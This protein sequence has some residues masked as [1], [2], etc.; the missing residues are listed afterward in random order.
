MTYIPEGISAHNL[1]Q[2]HRQNLG[3]LVSELSAHKSLTT[4]FLLEMVMS[5]SKGVCLTVHLI[6]RISD[7]GLLESLRHTPVSDL[8]N[9]LANCV[10]A[11]L[12]C[13]REA[14]QAG[15]DHTAESK[16]H[17]LTLIW[18][19]H[20][21]LALC[22]N[23]SL[24]FGEIN[25][26]LDGLAR[27]MCLAIFLKFVNTN[28]SVN[29]APHLAR[30]LFESYTTSYGVHSDPHRGINPLSVCVGMIVELASLSKPWNCVFFEEICFV[31]SRCKSQWL[32]AWEMRDRHSLFDEYSISFDRFMKMEQ[33]QPEA[34]VE[35]CFEYAFYPNQPISL[36][37]SKP[38][39][40]RH[41]GAV[42][43]LDSGSS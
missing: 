34:S 17:L 14:V 24:M 21:V 10:R 3:G 29:D 33:D 40:C 4:A 41:T 8:T 19:F 11:I 30:D 15:S 18:F 5:Q 16:F 2:R 23:V 43:E 7:H 35:I 39:S 32:A 1:Y 42:Y 27:P 26:K 22:S 38:D 6:E 36:P 12:E 28:I 20:S 25:S 37:T 31:S 9:L 13:Y